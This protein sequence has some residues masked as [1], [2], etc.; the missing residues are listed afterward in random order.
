MYGRGPPSCPDSL[1]A[2]QLNI[3]LPPTPKAA[4][5]LTLTAVSGSVSME[6]I[7]CCLYNT[8]LSGPIQSHRGSADHRSALP[9]LHDHLNTRHVVQLGVC[10]TLAS[11]TPWYASRYPSHAN[12]FAA[13]FRD[14]LIATHISPPTSV[15]CAPPAPDKRLA[16]HLVFHTFGVE[17]L[18]K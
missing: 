8:F 13:Y 15:P 2:G 6:K 12:V 14:I 3:G 17:L 10:Q 11:G 18:L 1:S 4:H 9:L 16:G 5:L 7:N